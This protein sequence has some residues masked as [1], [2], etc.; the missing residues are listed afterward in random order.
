M[1]PEEDGPSSSSPLIR[2][3]LGTKS[4]LGQGEHWVQPKHWMQLRRF[5]L[6][7]RSLGCL[8]VPII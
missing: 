7:R 3:C 6:Q 1:A 2:N 8:Q 5:A 4:A